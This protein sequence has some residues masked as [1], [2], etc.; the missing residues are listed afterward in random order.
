[1]KI[2]QD[3]NLENLVNEYGFKKNDEV[4]EYRMENA[5]N[6]LNEFFSSILV[7]EAETED[8]EIRFYYSDDLDDENKDI[9]DYAV[10][11]PNVLLQMIKDG[12]VEE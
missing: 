12:I 4:Y 10:K 2:R 5:T 11:I 9:I 1:M 7:N 8:R 6:K 3:Y